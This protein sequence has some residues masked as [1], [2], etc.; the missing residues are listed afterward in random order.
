MDR[1]H[2]LSLSTADDMSLDGDTIERQQPLAIVHP[3]TILAV[4]DI[5]SIGYRILFVSRT[6]IRIRIRIYSAGV[7]I[8]CLIHRLHRPI[9]G[10]LVHYQRSSTHIHGTSRIVMLNLLSQ[11]DKFSMVSVPVESILADVSDDDEND[12]HTLKEGKSLEQ[13]LA[14]AREEE[15][16]SLSQTIL[17]Q[18]LPDD[19]LTCL[20][21]ERIRATCAAQRNT[22][23][24]PHDPIMAP[25]SPSI[26][27]TTGTQAARPY[28]PVNRV[29]LVDAHDRPF[30]EYGHLD[31]A[32]L[33][34]E[35]DL[36][37]QPSSTA[38][39]L[40]ATKS[41]VLYSKSL[42]I[43]AWTDVSKEVVLDYIKEEFGIAN[44]QYICVC[45]EISD[46][47][48]R[49][50]LHIQIIFKEKIK[51]RRPF[52]DEITGTNCHYQVTTNDLAWNEYIKKEG[53]YIEFNSF[54]STRTRGSKQWSSSSAVAIRSNAS[55]PR[56]SLS[57]AA[58]T[59]AL[60]PVPATTTAAAGGRTTRATTA[61]EER[62]QY[63]KRVCVEAID[64][65]E[66]NVSE[67]M[68]HMRQHMPERFVE[69]GTWY[70]CFHR[71]TYT[72]AQCLFVLLGI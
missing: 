2:P 36:P 56:Q 45:E 24:G 8:L 35:L 43:T 17:S 37:A 1:A 20:V 64:K 3:A 51:R 40:S 26:V 13:I 68:D 70:D 10:N 60:P 67:A 7:P 48:H 19:E 38:S 15:L 31:R 69:R 12:Q 32:T 16:Q 18:P 54:K 33:A 49:Q 58:S 28:P 63:V 61:A 9:V 29:G 5:S 34:K 21:I 22:Q 72:I 50:H 52:L 42:A 27:S 57:N 39:S 59:L 44:L 23:G 47:N 4:S 53:N 65:A 25:L 6:S 41:M 46:V 66:R 55:T 71:S 30:A 14:E 11:C 62:R